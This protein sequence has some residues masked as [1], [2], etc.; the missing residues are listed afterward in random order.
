MPKRSP[1]EFIADKQTGKTHEPE[2]IR[3]FIRSFVEGGIP[4]Y[5]MAAWLM[6]VYFRGMELSETAALTE[7]MIESGDRISFEGLSPLGD[8]HS[9]GGVGD[10]ITLILAPLLTAAGI[11]VPTI[12]GRGLGHTGGTLDKLESIPG[13]RTDLSVQELT[14]QV[15][16]MGLAF[17]AQTKDIVPADRRMYALRDVTSTVRSF[18]LI[19][20]SILSK[21]V[22]EGIEAI[23]FD[24]KCGHGAFMVAEEDAWTL[25]R[26][27]VQTA[28]HFGL[29]SAALVTSMNHPLG[30]TVGNWLETDECLKALRGEGVRDDMR[31]L[32]LALGGTLLALMG[33]SKSS[34]EGM[35][36]IQT[37]WDE[38]RGFDVFKQAVMRQGGDPK[39]LEKG[40]NPHPATAQLVIVAESDGWLHGINALEIGLSGVAL[41]AGRRNAEEE[42]DP[43][44]GFIFHKEMGDQVK[45]G[46]PLI[47][48]LGPS[49]NA[50][51][52]LVER[53]KN[54]IDL[55]KV[56][57]E[58]PP[59]IRGV[60]SASGEEGW[61]SF[62]ERV[63][64]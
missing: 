23:V 26:W 22:A 32:T 63:L 24:V 10:K 3:D 29:K 1:V 35:D 15:K 64:Q 17:G 48:I 8:K 4:D 45:S 50:C 34:S 40:A 27:L 13:M 33:K 39:T 5:Q 54:A 59:L 55:R 14:D 62:K 46:E 58:I 9:T 38:G 30:E 16:E 49:E 28:T 2:Q 41:G 43:A 36:L 12:T 61:E 60:V 7:A 6:A 44:A 18:P 11:N 21:K 20:S 37:L 42:I 47:T 56:P 19:T 25:A 52:E 31:E 53:V 57:L 51:N